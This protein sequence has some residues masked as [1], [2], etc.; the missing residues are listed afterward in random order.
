MPT[1]SQQHREEHRRGSVVGSHVHTPAR[2]LESSS[3][4]SAAGIRRGSGWT[5]YPLYSQWPDYCLARRKDLIPSTVWT[6]AWNRPRIWFSW[7][8]AFQMWE[9]ATS[10]IWGHYNVTPSCRG[11]S[12][13]AS[14][15]LIWVA[16]IEN[17]K[18]TIAMCIMEFAWTCLWI[19]SAV[20]VFK[21]L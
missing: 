16:I 7:L 18:W 8:G 11:D 1:Y 12:P 3:T 20:L 21:G 15:P 9:L 2:W 17:L 6:K 14:P 13:L 19:Q 5:W 10:F 4:F